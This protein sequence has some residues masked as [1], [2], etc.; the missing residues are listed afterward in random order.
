MTT[1]L[2][3]LGNQIAELKAELVAERRTLWLIARAYGGIVLERSHMEDYPGDDRVMIAQ[4]E[5]PVTG[6]ISFNASVVDEQ[7]QQ[8]SGK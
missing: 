1:A 5:N 4:L 8:G 3:D 6:T 2:E 7:R